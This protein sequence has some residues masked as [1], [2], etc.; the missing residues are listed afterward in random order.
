MPSKCASKKYLSASLALTINALAGLLAALWSSSRPGIDSRD[1]GRLDDWPT[2]C[3]RLPS[4]RRKR[5][6]THREQL[7][8]GGG[9][10]LCAMPPA[11]EPLPR[12]ASHGVPQPREKQPLPVRRPGLTV[13][14]SARTTQ[15]VTVRVLNPSQGDELATLFIGGPDTST[16]PAV[17]VYRDGTVDTH[18]PTLYPPCA[19]PEQRSELNLH[20]DRVVEQSRAVRALE[21][22]QAALAGHGDLVK[23]FATDV[24][25]LSRHARWQ[26]AV[27]TALL[28]D[29]IQPLFAGQRLD[30]IAVARLRTDAHTTHRHLLPVWRRRTRHGRVLLLETPLGDGLTL[31]D[32]ACGIMNAEDAPFAYEPDDARLAALIRA[33]RPAERVAALAWADPDVRN[34]TE[35][36]RLAGAD[37]PAVF[38]E[39]VRRK[40]RRL[41][42]E[43]DRRRALTM[44]AESR[45]A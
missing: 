41:A 31:H 36:A 16:P 10:F 1:G 42:A 3:P 4:L 28:G 30:D 40:C 43:L 45:R 6:P 34:W 12:P 26:E 18:R 7:L 29:W 22:R 38:G 33:L 37:D 20:F 9:L 11:V 24:L 32:L 15:L 21:A 44:G 35:A 14:R 39:R 19:T 5:K 17:T 13:R 23:A 27:S 2:L 25:G 8:P